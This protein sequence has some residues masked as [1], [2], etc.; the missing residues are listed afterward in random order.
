MKTAQR[1]WAA[2]TILMAGLVPGVAFMSGCEPLYTIATS[3][4]TLT[5]G[6]INVASVVATDKTV[7]DH[8]VSLVTGH[9]CSMVRYSAGGY[10]CVQPLPAN[11]PVETRLYCYRSIGNITCYDKEIP[12]E[13][14]RLVSDPRHVISSR[15]L[16][17]PMVGPLP[18]Q[19]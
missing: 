3:P 5:G 18:G 4:V 17:G 1:S 11:A 15:D 13:G 2:R 6:A 8:V 10:Y 7:P 19:R 12:G 14:S 16:S 9:D